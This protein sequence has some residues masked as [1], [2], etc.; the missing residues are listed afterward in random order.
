MGREL[1][2]AKSIRFVYGESKSNLNRCRDLLPQ[3]PFKLH[4]IKAADEF[5]P[6]GCIIRLT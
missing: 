5:L 4:Q 3:I 1:C 2:P 6:E